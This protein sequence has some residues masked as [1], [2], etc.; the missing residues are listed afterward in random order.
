MRSSFFALFY[1]TRWW[2]MLEDDMSPHAALI[3]W[4]NMSRC[5]GQNELSA[6][7]TPAGGAGDYSRERRGRKRPMLRKV[8][9]NHGS[10]RPAESFKDLE[11]CRDGRGRGAGWRAHTSFE[12]KTKV[13]NAA[14]SKL[15]LIKLSLSCRF[16]YHL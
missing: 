2:C 14:Q 1:K 5:C 4:G 8:C 3:S 13:S 12:K 10:R 16:L 15:Y 7:L 6:G 9:I 11:T